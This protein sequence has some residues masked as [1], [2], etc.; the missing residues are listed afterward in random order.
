MSTNPKDLVGVKKAPLR[1]VPPALAIGVA[2]AMAEGAEKYG[3]F[4]WRKQPVSMM[5]YIE[6][7]ERHIAALK[8]GQDNTEDS[9]HS[10]LAHIGA[11]VGI[12][13]DA[14]ANG[15]LID[16][17]FEPGPAPDMLRALDKTQVPPSV[18]ICP[19]HQVPFLG[20]QH[21]LSCP[22][23]QCYCDPHGLTINGHHPL[24]Q[25]NRL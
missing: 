8:D 25:V 21:L 12:L 10:H 6:A 4:N 1:Y 11:S 14:E 24:C 18:C 3:P 22:A 9:G 13:L 2:P 16:D 7:M 5:T 17:R 20:G 19:P 23:R 15:T